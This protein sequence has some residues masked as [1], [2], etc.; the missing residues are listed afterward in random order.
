MEE[1]GNKALEYLTAFEELAKQYAP[2]VVNAGLTVVQISAFSEIVIGV[3]LL[4]VSIGG[5]FAARWVWKK[6]DD[7]FCAGLAGAAALGA[8]I[9]SGVHLLSVWT[10]VGIFNPKLYIAYKLFEKVL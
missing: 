8:G 5:F 7:E 1:L 4:A 10:W 6:T 3:V 2:D 9:A